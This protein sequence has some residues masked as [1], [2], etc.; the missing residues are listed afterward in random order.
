MT[1]TPNRAGPTQITNATTTIVTAA[2]AA[3]YRIVRTIVITNSGASPITVTAGIGTSNVD[4]AAKR[5]FDAVPLQPG[6]VLE[7]SGFLPLLGGAS[8]DLLYALCS[9]VTGATITVG[10]V[11][12]P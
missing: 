4:T 6:D 11:D 8:P 10:T 3:T 9:V 5:I 7:W 2:G 12:G 1:E